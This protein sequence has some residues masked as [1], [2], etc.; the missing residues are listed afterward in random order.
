MS[1]LG[2]SLGSCTNL[3]CLTLC[4]M[5]NKNNKYLK[6]KL[7]VLVNYPFCL[8]TRKNEIGDWVYML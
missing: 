1:A 5:Y 4:L 7:N 2:H 3:T 8:L 6:I